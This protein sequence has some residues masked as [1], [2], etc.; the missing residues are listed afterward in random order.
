M[1]INCVWSHHV[2]TFYVNI[3][4]MSDIKFHVIILKLSIFI[5]IST[6]CYK[7]Y[8]FIFF[9]V[10]NKLLFYFFSVQM[11][12][13]PDLFSYSCLSFPGKSQLA[14]PNHYYLHKQIMYLIYYHCHSLLWSNDNKL[15]FYLL[16]TILCLPNVPI[17][18][19]P[20]YSLTPY[21][22]LHFVP[23]F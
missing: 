4:F 14:L 22:F 20:V 11:Q 10:S 19:F 21:K 6:S 2:C 5:F 13:Y 18:H 1:H 15:T 23:Y 8:S 3:F 9:Y 16:D 12:Y 17:Q 7:I